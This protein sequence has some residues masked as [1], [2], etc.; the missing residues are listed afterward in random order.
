[1]PSAPV[2]LPGAPGA[3]HQPGEG[4]ARTVGSNLLEC[5]DSG[6]SFILF[7]SSFSME[8]AV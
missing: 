4:E 5:Q 1:M 6:P 8:G 7:F 3:A 2:R